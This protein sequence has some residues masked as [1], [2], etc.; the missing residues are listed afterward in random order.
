M[1]R[2]VKWQG[3]ENSVGYYI[4]GGVK[5]EIYWIKESESDMIRFYD[6]NGNEITVNRGKTYICFTDTEDV[7]FK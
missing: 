3:G 4:S 6:K 2:L 5:Q 1:H 7:T